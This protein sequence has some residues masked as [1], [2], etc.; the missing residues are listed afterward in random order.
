MK[1]RVDVK[2]YYEDTDALGVVYYANYLRYFERGRSELVE[3]LGTPIADWNTAGCNI[4]VFKVNVTYHKPAK[5]GDLCHVQT[6][7]GKCS[8]YRLRM[9][10]RFFRGDELMTDAE[11]LLVCLDEHMEL[12]EFPEELF[13]AM[14][15]AD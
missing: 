14:G 5:L 1:T 6:E 13:P 7:V 11:V 9:N 8:T 10:Q 15:L 12:R 4:V 2:V 3:S